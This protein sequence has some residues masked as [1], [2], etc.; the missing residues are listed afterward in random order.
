[1]RHKKLRS[2]V[3]NT[4]RKC[5]SDTEYTDIADKI[6]DIE[7]GYDSDPSPTHTPDVEK[8]YGLQN[9]KEI[10]NPICDGPE[11]ELFD[12][13][14]HDIRVFNSLTKTEY[15]KKTK[16][17][18]QSSITMQNVIDHHEKT[19]ESLILFKN[20]IG[21]LEKLSDSEKF[22]ETV[23][24]GNIHE[25]LASVKNLLAGIEKSACNINKDI[26]KMSGVSKG[27]TGI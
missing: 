23:K 15:V 1:M 19:I 4:S 5:F 17:G 12:A 24:S 14:S 2:R 16:S 13:L 20:I 25:K 26:H 21:T 10:H 18:E 6:D 11:K 7:R 3:K 8:V 9:V 22:S 27:S